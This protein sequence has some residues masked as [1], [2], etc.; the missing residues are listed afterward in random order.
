MIFMYAINNRVQAL[1]EL[2]EVNSDQVQW[3]IPSEHI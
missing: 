2:T 1:F 3:F